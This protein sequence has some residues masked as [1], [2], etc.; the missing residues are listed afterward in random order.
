MRLA[1]KIALVTGAGGRSGKGEPAAVKAHRSDAS[2]G[3]KLPL[4]GYSLDVVYG[5]PTYRLVV[6]RGFRWSVE[7]TPTPP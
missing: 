5:M 4:T 6:S 3:R 1:D 7:M 2:A